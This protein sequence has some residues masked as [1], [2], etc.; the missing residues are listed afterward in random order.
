MVKKYTITVTMSDI[1]PSGA[2]VQTL[3][4]VTALHALIGKPFSTTKLGYD[5]IIGY[6]T[7]NTCMYI[8]YLLHSTGYKIT[9][10]IILCY[11]I[12]S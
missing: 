3:Q 12:I 5:K 4:P 1:N 6:C 8:L 2:P 9:L 10:S 7:L 11:I